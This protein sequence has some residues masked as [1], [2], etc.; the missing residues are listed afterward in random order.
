M[1]STLAVLAANRLLAALPGEDRLRLR[2]LAGCEPVELGIAEALRNPGD[3]IRHVY[4][5]T[6]GSISWVM[7]VD[8]GPGLEVGLVGNEGMAR[9]HP[10]AGDR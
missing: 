7:P 1:S 2:L 9:N 8:G 6:G 3:P 10:H 4:F 5:P